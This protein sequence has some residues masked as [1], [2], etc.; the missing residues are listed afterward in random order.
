[1]K[2]KL[3]KEIEKLNL[4]DLVQVDWGDASTGKSLATGKEIDVPASSWGIFI[5][6]L[7]EKNKHIILAQNHFHYA[8]GISDLDYTAVPLQWSINIKIVSKQHIHP[9]V[10]EEM[11]RSF[12]HGCRHQLGRLSRQRRIRHDRLD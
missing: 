1:M 11:L 3:S 4:G 10:A 12:A 6:I 8:S 7:G 2:N 9:E 5:G